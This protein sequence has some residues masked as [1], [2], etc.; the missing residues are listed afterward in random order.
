[1]KKKLLLS[2]LLFAFLLTAVLF[3]C[4]KKE[5]PPESVEPTEPTV[6]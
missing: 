1:M 2:V 5:V 6:V 3:A 4:G